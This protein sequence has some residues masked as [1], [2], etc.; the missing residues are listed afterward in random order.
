MC[1]SA[2]VLKK[3]PKACEEKTWKNWSLIN[4]TLKGARQRKCVLKAGKD[5]QKPHNSDSPNSGRRGGEESMGGQSSDIKE[6][7]K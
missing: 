5:A 1:R 6:E 2:K 7:N 3:T 4:A